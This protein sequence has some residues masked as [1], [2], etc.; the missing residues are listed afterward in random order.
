MPDSE[1]LQQRALGRAAGGGDD[2]RAEVMRNLNRRHAH[3]ARARVDE[4]ALAGPHPRD[5]VERVPRG[6]ENHGQ[7]RCFFK[8]QSVRDDAHIAGPRH[9]TGRKSEHRE[10]KHAVSR[11]HVRDSAADGFHHTSHFIAKDAGIRRLCGIKGQR[12]EHVTKIHAGGFHFDHHFARTA[13]RQGE[14]H[15]AQR[16]EKPAFAGLKPQ[17]HRAIKHLLARLQTAIDAPHIAR[18]S[19]E[20]DLAFGDFLLQLIPKQHVV[21]SGCGGRQINAPTSEVGMLIGHHAHQTDG[22]G[23]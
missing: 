22:W 12:L 19:S 20:G 6:H 16:I 23:L 3:A 2:F 21:R 1:R 18:L 14:G 17:R 10:A 9:R 15:E 7:S 11:R 8:R 13:G 4:D 5:V